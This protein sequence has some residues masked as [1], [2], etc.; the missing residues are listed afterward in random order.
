[1]T[2]D[3]ENAQDFDDAVSIMRLPSGNYLLGVHIADVSHYVKPGTTLDGEAY[4]RGTS[5]YFPDLTLPMLPE[6]L[7]N[8]LC[9][10]RPREEKL[11][12]SV[13]LEI[14]ARGNVAGVEFTPSL[15]QTAER[16][17]YTSVYN[18]F[19]GDTEER[20][21]YAPLVK[22]LL[23]MRELASILR[24]KRVAEGSLDFDILEPELIYQEGVLQRVESFEQNEA[25]K[26]IE[27]FMV[28]ANV[29]VASFLS[30]KNIPSLYRI[31]PRPG[32]AD[33]EKL[34]EILLHF[35]LSL[36]LPDRIESKDLQG[37][38]ERARGK[39]AEKFITFEVLRSLRL[40]AYSVENEGHYGLAKKDYAHFTSPIR[41][42]P[43]LLVHRALRKA[44]SGKKGDAITEAVA[45]HCSEQERRADQA[46]KE[47]VEWRIFRFLKGKLGEEFSGTIVDFSKAGPVVELDD[48]FVQGLIPYS[49][50]GNDYYYQKTKS[51][52]IGRRRGKR[53]ELGDRVIVILVS[54][55]PFWRR[56]GLLLKKEKGEERP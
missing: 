19:E 42:Y 37:V 55:D 44:L 14:D 3:G 30:R 28:A 34:R 48:Y 11:T 47:L 23:L 5:V 38:L 31:H 12:F 33:L 45:L 40:A 17:T 24:K 22:D 26:L 52:L 18:I 4:A 15:V 54:V 25:H 2:I 49:E 20:K 16:L 21:K 39:P 6:R 46:E 29:A 7:S 43:D 8:D 27:E 1:V 35:G 56:M 32:K 41:R 9:S 51:A 36:P 10:L 50:L 53:Y 13:L